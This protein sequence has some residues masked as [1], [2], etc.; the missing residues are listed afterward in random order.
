MLQQKHLEKINTFPEISPP[1]TRILEREVNGN[2]AQI[3]VYEDE[4]GDKVRKLVVEDETT[5]KTTLG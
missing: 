4:N 3:G 5:G 2:K 1:E